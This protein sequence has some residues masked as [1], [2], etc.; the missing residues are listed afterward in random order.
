MDYRVVWSPEAIEDV[1]S[2][3]TYIA[4]DSIRYATSVVEK[5]L[6]DSRSLS[7]SPYIG[8]IVPEFQNE[9]IREQ[10]AYS[11][12]LIYRIEGEVVTIAPVIHGKRLID[13][14]SERIK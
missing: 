10:I 6:E 11:Y 9:S 12:R 3:A 4:R 13:T 5:I 1:E 8:R 14:F 2:I 7:L